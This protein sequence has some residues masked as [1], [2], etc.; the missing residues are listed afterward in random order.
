M[1]VE[2]MTA[3]HLLNAIAHH[4]T[5]ANTLEEMVKLGYPDTF[6]V[7]RLAAME[8]TLT[9]LR[10]ELETRDPTKDDENDPHQDPGDRW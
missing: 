9:T 4:Q 7:P 8:D 1:A 6:L 3:S 2:E 5:Q 10:S